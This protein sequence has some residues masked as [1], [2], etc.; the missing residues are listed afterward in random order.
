[1]ESGAVCVEKAHNARNDVLVDRSTC[2][3][4]TAKYFK[5]EFI[6]ARDLMVV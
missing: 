2:R 6:V 3:G 5:G 1:M 4:R